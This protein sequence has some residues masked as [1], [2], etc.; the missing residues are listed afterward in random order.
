MEFLVIAQLREACSC[1]DRP[2]FQGWMSERYV[3]PEKIEEEEGDK[4]ADSV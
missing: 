3:L 2:M 4:K 1:R